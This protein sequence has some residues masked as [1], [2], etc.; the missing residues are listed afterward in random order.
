MQILITGGNS[1]LAQR[2]GAALAANAT[3]RLFDRTF[4]HPVA[5]GLE[6]V[7]GDPCDPNVVT[8]AL[9]GCD[10]VI[11]LAPYLPGRITEL[12]GESAAITALDDATRGSFVLANGARQAGVDRIIVI[13]TLDFFDRFP[14]HY[15]INE[16]WRPRPTPEISQLS[17][18]LAELSIRENTRRG[19]FNA[20]GLRVGQIVDDEYAAQHPYD[21]RWVHIEDV[22]HGIECALRYRTEYKP[23]WSVFH[24]MAAGPKSK[25]RHQMAVSASAEFGYEPKHDFQPYWA[26][27]TQEPQRDQ[28]PW[29]ELL[30]P[31]QIP[32]RPIHRVVIF[33]AGGP[34]GAVT[35]QELSSSYQLR[36]TDLRPITEIAAEAKPQAPGAPLPIPLGAPHETWQVDVR[37]PAQVMAA[38]EGMDAIINCTVVRPHPVD[39]FLVNTIGAYNVMRAAVAHNIRRV[40]HTGPLVQHL[41]GPGDHSGDYDLHV[42]APPRPYD[43]LYIH[44]KYLGAEI[45]RVFAEYYGL[46]VPALLFMMLYNPTMPVPP[47]PFMISWPDTGRALRRALE[48][49]SLP[50]P[51]EMVNI[52]ADLPHGRYDFTKARQLL[53]WQPRDGLEDFWQEV[54]E[55]SVSST[56]AAQ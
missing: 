51:F 42:D 15:K 33:G 5:D 21:P 45:C 14:A 6:Q 39:A 26:T 12:S 40:V 29:R 4:S 53:D 35:T 54:A 3:V 56:T 47:W 55:D 16:V 32:S 10:T 34:M 38:V 20:I 25:L 28:R 22:I 37:D 46:E 36:V 50:S 2:I 19:P 13:S 8:G 49:V 23:Y 31:Q 41:K 27:A 30:A 48:V 1:H 18:W 11:H 52:S 9:Q 44:S 24:L 7:S 17:P 43:H